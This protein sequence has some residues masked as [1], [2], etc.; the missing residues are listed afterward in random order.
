MFSKKRGVIIGSVLTLLSSLSVTYFSCTKPSGDPHTCNYVYC[1][2]G[3][4][5]SQGKCTCPTGYEGPRCATESVSKFVGIWKVKQIVIGSTKASYIGKDST[6]SINLKKSG[7]VTTFFIDN[8]YGDASYNN[9]V[10]ALDSITST[11]FRFD[12]LPAY[13]MV[14]DH[15]RI[16]DGK[17]TYGPNDRS[18]ESVIRV[19][20]LDATAN[21]QT[22][23]LSLTMSPF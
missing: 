8:F 10:C 9:L 3:G 11:D 13:H 4:V 7:T 22:D 6:Y 15:F 20:R 23:T 18:I 14:Y 21:W 1:D 5:C 17:G 19:R 2:N 16:L 12:T